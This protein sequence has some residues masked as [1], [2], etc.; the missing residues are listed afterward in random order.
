MDR[1]DPAAL[2]ADL[3]AVVARINRLANQR[4]ELP[5]PFAQARLLATIE[6]QG[7]ARISD[8][9]A[10]DHCSQPTMT[11][12]VRR[13]EDAG[14]VSRTEDAADARV[15]LIEI[16][17][18]GRAMLNRVRADRSAAINPYLDHLDDAQRGALVDAIQ[19]LRG[20]LDDAQ[21]DRRPK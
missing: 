16:T 18:A 3:L 10:I 15:V 8:L 13:L 21:Q 1:Q 6:D 19:V 14:L 2:G 17:D 9:A 11:T 20:L 4:I 12:Q 7:R 5:L